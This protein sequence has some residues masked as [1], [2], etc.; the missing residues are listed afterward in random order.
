[1]SAVRVV[2]KKKSSVLKPGTHV[3]NITPPC[4][5]NVFKLETY[6]N[7]IIPPWVE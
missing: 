3:N 5:S 1:M 2:N 4:S 7:Y 6:A